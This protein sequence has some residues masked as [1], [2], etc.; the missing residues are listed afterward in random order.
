M[1]QLL[2]ISFF[3]LFFS[4][5]KA[6]TEISNQ[7]LA[8]FVRYYKSNQPDSIYSL[9]TM[10]MKTAVD[11]AGTKQLL[12]TIKSQLGDIVRSRYVGSPADGFYGYYLRFQKPIV[13][14]AV[15]IQEGQIA[16]ITQQAIE[17]DKNDPVELESPDNIFVDN[18]FGTVYGTLLM[19]DTT[20]TTGKLPV[21]LLIAG[22]GPTDRNMNQ[23]MS[24]RSNSFLMLARALAAS[25]I[26]SVRYDKR[27]VRKSTSTQAQEDVKLDDFVSDAVLFIKQLKAD[28]RFSEV[29]VAGYSEG[30]TIGLYA[31]LQTAPDAY[32]SLSG[33]ANDIGTILKKQIRARASAADYKTTVEILDSLQA[34]KLY[35]KQLPTSLSS[36][37]GLPIQPFLISSM[38][39]QPAAKIAELKIPVLIVAGTTDLQIGIEESK[40]LK[41]AKPDA[42]LIIINGMNHV[43]KTAPKD[44]ELNSKTYNAPDL[45]LHSDLATAL[46]KFI[47]QVH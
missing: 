12:S 3:I 1:K 4:A 10:Q 13:D 31:A 25:G 34:G 11:P 2:L 5:A 39:Y 9:F 8:K 22:S 32:I 26:A 23:G 33:A 37:F 46:I 24:L 29:I 35:H 36:I 38:S 43:M 19:P 16:G 18:A 30:S 20:K 28:P 27:S 7:T 21:V 14:I 47:K 41:N 45:P 17:A 6:Q 42:G 15:T 40:K 44:R